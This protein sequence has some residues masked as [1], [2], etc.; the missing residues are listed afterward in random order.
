MTVSTPVVKT[1]MGSLR[2]LDI[3]YVP[4]PD[5]LRVQIL[6]SLQ[7]L[8]KGQLHHFAA[9]IDDLQILVVWDDEPEKLLQ[10]AQTLEQRF[11]EIIWGNTQ[12]EEEEQDEKKEDPEISVEEL[13]P[14][15]LEEALSREYRPVRLENAVVV[16]A[17]LTLSF[18]CLGL[19]WRHLAMEV[20]VDNSYTRLALAAVGPIQ[21]FASLVG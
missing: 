1:I 20:M 16:G 12:A 19:G 17:T 6:G 3:D 15:Q 7:D 2:N 9:F 10:R 14:A 21:L 11:M 5:G 18:V 8:P 4:L 13:D